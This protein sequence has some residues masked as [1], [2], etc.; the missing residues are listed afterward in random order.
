MAFSKSFP[1][2]SDKSN[3]PIWEDIFLTGDEEEAVEREARVENVR[4]MK[5]CL[6]DAKAVLAEKQLKPYQADVTRIAIS[7][8]EKR[9]SHAVWQK[10]RK[11]RDK[12]DE[13]FSQG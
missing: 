12:F 1:R 13:N 4:L 9:A 2:R 11:C 10:E 3:Y 5:E 8:F 7:L 6:D